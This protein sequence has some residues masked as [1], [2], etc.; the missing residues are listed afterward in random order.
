MVLPVGVYRR[1]ILQRIFWP[2]S[3]WKRLMY[4]KVDIQGR[5][6]LNK[7]SFGLAKDHYSKRGP[8]T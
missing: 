4:A 2:T 3:Y 1:K 6:G 7:V 5:F 8:D